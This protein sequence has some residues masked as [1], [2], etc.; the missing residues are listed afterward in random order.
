VDR[1]LNKLGMTNALS[2]GPLHTLTSCVDME[3]SAKSG[4]LP[5]AVSDSTMFLYRSSTPKSS[6]RKLR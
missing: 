4:Q 2:R 1:R 5:T 6:I 3:D